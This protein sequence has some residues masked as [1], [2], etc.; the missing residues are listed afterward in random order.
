MARRPALA[1]EPRT[2]YASA[3]SNGQGHFEGSTAKVETDTHW[4]TPARCFFDDDRFSATHNQFQG[5]STWCER[6]AFFRDALR[7][8]ENEL[9]AWR[10]DFN[11]S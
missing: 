3:H 6:K 1:G 9:V 2:R 7:C 11:G 8:F 5:S 10:K 4:A